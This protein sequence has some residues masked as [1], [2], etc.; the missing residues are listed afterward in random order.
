MSSGYGHL[1][2]TLFHFLIYPFP[3]LPLP[4]PRLL[5]VQDREWKVRAGGVL[6]F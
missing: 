2:K 5:A 3:V 1:R 4:Q 6:G